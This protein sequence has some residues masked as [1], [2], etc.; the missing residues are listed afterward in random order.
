MAEVIEKE[1]ALYYTVETSH[2]IRQLYMG[3]KRLTIAEDI[4]R[5]VAPCVLCTIGEFAR[6]H[7]EAYRN[8]VDAGIGARA[9]DG[10]RRIIAKR[11]PTLFERAID[12]L[13]AIPPD[14]LELRVKDL[15]PNFNLLCRIAIVEEDLTDEFER[16]SDLYTIRLLERVTDDNDMEYSLLGSS[17]FTYVGELINRLSDRND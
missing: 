5:L 4:D 13:A 6:N 1:K 8:T 2:Q 16:N 12:E 15:P 9:I 7:M 10:I 14:F 17:A 11:L 3:Y